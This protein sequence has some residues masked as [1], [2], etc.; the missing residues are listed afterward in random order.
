M[1]RPNAKQSCALMLLAL[2]FLLTSCAT[3]SPT[4]ATACPVFPPIPAMSE[5]TPSR[6][7]SESAQLLMESWLNKLTALPQT[8]KR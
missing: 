8:D 1:L 4:S 3:N 2:S 5:P 7:F 6:S